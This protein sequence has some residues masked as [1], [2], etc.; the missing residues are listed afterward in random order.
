[1]AIRFERIAEPVKRKPAA[2][3]EEGLKE[4]LT[5]AKGEAKPARV[6]KV[7]VHGERDRP[8]MQPKVLT[9]TV[10]AKK[11]AKVATKRRK[12]ETEKPLPNIPHKDIPHTESIPH[13]VKAPKITPAERTKAWRAENADKH[14]AS[15]RDYMR[16]RRAKP[17]ASA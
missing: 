5:I 9:S 1:M 7:K 6:A 16:K 12:A 11:P 4:A 17:E 8:A 3:I 2:K 14:R 15:H 13:K 10:E